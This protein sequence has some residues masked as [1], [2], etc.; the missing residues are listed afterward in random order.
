MRSVTIC[1]GWTGR[2]VRQKVLRKIRWCILRKGLHDGTLGLIELQQKILFHTVSN[3]ESTK[4]M[5]EASNV[6]PVISVTSVSVFCSN[7]G[8][9]LPDEK[10]AVIWTRPWSCW[11]SICPF[12]VSPSWRED[13]LCCFATGWSMWGRVFRYW[14]ALPSISSSWTGRTKGCYTIIGTVWTDQ[15]KNNNKRGGE[16]FQYFTPS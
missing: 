8:A 4:S 1:A 13:I 11:S 15:R 12:L 9:R 16:L 7:S 6:P 3:G 5:A 14:P 10:A 2:H